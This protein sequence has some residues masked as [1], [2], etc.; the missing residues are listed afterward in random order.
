MRFENETIE[1]MKPILKEKHTLVEKINSKDFKY[2]NN[3]TERITHENV[4]YSREKIGL[5]A[6]VFLLNLINLV[7]Y[8]LNVFK[9]VKR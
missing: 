7:I 6:I 1:S 3:F 4:A 9:A 8:G 5:I 2:L